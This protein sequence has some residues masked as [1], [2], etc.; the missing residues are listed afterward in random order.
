MS[1]IG[2]I[3]E[4]YTGLIKAG[5]FLQSPL[6]LA[7][8]LF[9]GWQL[10]ESGRGKLMHLHDTASFFQ[11]LGIPFPE[12]NAHF[13]GYVESVGGLFLIFGFLTRLATIPLIIVMIVAFLTAHVDAV[14]EL[15]NDYQAFTQQAPFIFL[16]ALLILFAFGP[17]KISI[18][19]LAKRFLFKDRS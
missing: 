7:I 15:A 12:F 4:C 17:G 3:K 10:F 19:S 9:W 13:V 2:K 1:L 18:D 11:G 5:E 6:L 14:K 8:R 16:F